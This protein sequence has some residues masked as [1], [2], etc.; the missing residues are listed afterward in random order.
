MRRHIT[1][2]ALGFAVASC[3]VV[4]FLLPRYG[5]EKYGY[6]LQNAGTLT[7]LDLLRQ[8]PKVLGLPISRNMSVYG[9]NPEPER[10]Q[11]QRKPLIEN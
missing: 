4:L 6:G 2:F 8:I 3:V 11:I 10:T 5:R 9:V 1:S 7:K